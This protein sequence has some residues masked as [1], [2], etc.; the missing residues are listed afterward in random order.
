MTQGAESLKLG[1][2]D[3]GAEMDSAAGRLE[4]EEHVLHDTSSAAVSEQGATHG[5]VGT[6]HSDAMAAPS[7]GADQKSPL[8][9]VGGDNQAIVVGIDVG[10]SRRTVYT[11]CCCHRPIRTLWP[12]DVW[13]RPRAVA[14]VQARAARVLGKTVRR[15]C[16]V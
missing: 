12:C 15:Q 14:R 16:P 6:E 3:A 10:Q 5:Q 8:R 13:P 1:L 11:C 2:Q 9:A 4:D 7:A